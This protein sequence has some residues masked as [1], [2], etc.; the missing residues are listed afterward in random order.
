M[1]GPLFASRLEVV[2]NIRAVARRIYR[3]GRDERLG[4]HDVQQGNLID[5]LGN[6]LRCVSNWPAHHKKPA[7]EERHL[8][9]FYI[10][11]IAV[12]SVNAEW[13]K[14]GPR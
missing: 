6:I 1:T 4:A 9:M 5:T 12:T 10:Q 8:G 14:R 2:S 3:S 13:N 7:C 11:I